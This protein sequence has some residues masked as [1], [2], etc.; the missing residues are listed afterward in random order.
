MKL[1]VGL[2]NPGKEYKKTKHNIGF[3]AMDLLA[4]KMRSDDFSK[5]D[6]FKSELTCFELDGEK[7]FLAKPSTFMNLSGEAVQKIASY[8]KID[9]K[10]IAVVHDELDLPAGEIKVSFGRGAAGHN[11]VRSVIE[12]LGTEEFLRVRIG[13]GKDRNILK[14]IGLFD[15]AKIKKAIERSVDALLVWL[16]DGAEIAMQEANKRT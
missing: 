4:D 15:R 11:G 10:D 2:G 1:I 12:K 14:K 5:E 13:V 9:P 7:V 6:K 8:Y 3:M 16:K